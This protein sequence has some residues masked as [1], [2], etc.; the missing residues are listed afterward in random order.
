LIYL[1]SSALL[2]LLFEEDESAALAQWISE[3]AATPMVSSELVRIEVVRAA[4]R[5][6]PAVVPAARTLVSQLDLVPLTGTLIDEAADAGE[7]I[8]RTLDAIHLASV[9][10]I[11]ADLTAFVAYDTRLIAA[12]ASVG[13]GAVR[14]SASTST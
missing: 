6:D 7:P 5:L 10:S 14:P 13:I 11:Q 1:D 9:L 8:L 4:R 12:V 2:K 3:R